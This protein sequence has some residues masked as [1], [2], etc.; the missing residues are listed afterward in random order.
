MKKFLLQVTF[1]IHLRTLKI[2]KINFIYNQK[3]LNLC[4]IFKNYYKKI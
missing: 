2:C 1:L 3:K 4:K